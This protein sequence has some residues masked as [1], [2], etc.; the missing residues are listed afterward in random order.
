MLDRHALIVLA[1]LAG[2][3]PAFAAGVPARGKDL[4]EKKCA[5]CHAIGTTGDSP[6]PKSPP[7]RTLSQRYPI[8][9]LQEALAEGITVGHEGVEMPEFRMEPR[10]IDD[11]LAFL[12]SINK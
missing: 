4:A 6:N 12:K 9:S 3:A 10:E 8:D 5:I 7:F 11:F 2:T 1:L